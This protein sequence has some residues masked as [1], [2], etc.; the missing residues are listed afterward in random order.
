MRT[1]AS[2]YDVSISALPVFFEDPFSLSTLF[3]L[4][5]PAVRWG[6]SVPVCPGVLATRVVLPVL[7]FLARPLLPPAPADRERLLRPTAHTQSP[8]VPML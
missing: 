4:P 7:K 3:P 2:R 1:R 5:A 6:L 8:Q